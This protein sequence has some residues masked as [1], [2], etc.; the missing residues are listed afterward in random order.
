M[1]A[2]E[3]KLRREGFIVTRQKTIKVYFEGGLMGAFNADLIVKDCIINKLKA[4]EL[5]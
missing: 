3:M 1:T 5:Q 2:L 4:V